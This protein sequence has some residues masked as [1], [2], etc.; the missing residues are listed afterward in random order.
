AFAPELQAPVGARIFGRARC[1]THRLGLMASM[2]THSATG[3]PPV[4]L[5]SFGHGGGCA[6][7]IPPGALEDVVAGIVGAPVDEPAGELLVGLDHG[8]DAA[9]VRVRANGGDLAVI[10]TS[11]FFTPVVDDPYDWGRI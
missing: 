3:T 9:A 6:C 7:K 1:N 4:R 2:A 5:T 8:D 11:D 10:N